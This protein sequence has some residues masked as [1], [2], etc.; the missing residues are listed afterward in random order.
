TINGNGFVGDTFNIAKFAG[1]GTFTGTSANDIF[2]INTK[3]VALSSAATGTGTST[4]YL[5]N[6]VSLKTTSGSKIVKV[7]AGFGTFA[8]GQAV[9]GPNIPA[10][11]TIA[12]INGTNLTLSAVATGTGTNT[13]VIGIVG[14]TITQI[15]LATTAG[16]KAADVVGNYRIATGKAIV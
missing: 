4:A 3:T 1:V 16:S 13:C 15:S 9:I 6:P 2:N 5:G 8:V 11:A 10:G 12:S 14:T 7:V